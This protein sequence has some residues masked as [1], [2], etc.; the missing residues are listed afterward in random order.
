MLSTWATGLRPSEKLGDG[1]DDAYET[2]QLRDEVS[3]IFIH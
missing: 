1:A 3:G 2:F